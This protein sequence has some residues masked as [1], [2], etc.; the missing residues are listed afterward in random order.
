MDR[1]AVPIHLENQGSPHPRVDVLH[2]RGVTGVT[3]RPGLDIPGAEANRHGSAR[4]QPGCADREAQTGGIDLGL[5]G[6]HISHYAS[7]DV[8]DS[9]H[10]SSLW[11]N[12]LP[13]D[14]VTPPCQQDLAIR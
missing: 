6:P 14:V 11:G 4:D 7:H 10:L 5:I 1:L 2:Q 3:G 9:Q 8:L 12:R 13:E